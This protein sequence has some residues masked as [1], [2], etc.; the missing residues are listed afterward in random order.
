MTRCDHVTAVTGGLGLTV[1]E[2]R[3]TI[4]GDPD[5]VW[6]WRSPDRE[7]AFAPPQRQFWKPHVTGKNRA[8]NLEHDPRQ[9]RKA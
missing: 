2:T 9:E 1:I 5:A 6:Q 7:G 3:W 8:C 4:E